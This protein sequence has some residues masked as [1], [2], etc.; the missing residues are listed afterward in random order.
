MR[1]PGRVPDEGAA[2][3]EQVAAT[4]AAAVLVVMVLLAAG[5][6]GLGTE[7]VR[8][9]CQ[10]VTG[11]D[12]GAPQAVPQPQDEEFIPPPCMLAEDGESAGYTVKIAFVEIGEEYGFIRQEFADGTVRLTAVDSATIGLVKSGDTKFIDL[13]KLGDDAE[14]GVSVEVGGGLTFGYGDTWA[15]DSAAQE[16]AMRAQ[17]DDYLIQQQQ[18]RRDSHGGYAL[19][20][21]I[22]NGYV[23]PP[24]D[25]GVSFSKISLDG[26]FSAAFGLQAPTGGTDPAGNDRYIDPNIGVALTLDAGYEVVVEHDREA[27]TQSY[28]YSLSG[29]AAA[30]AN[31]V[32]GSGEISGTT[33]GS[34]QITRNSRG[35]I[36]EISMVSTREGGISGGLEVKNPVSGTKVDGGA[37]GG[38]GSTSATVTTTTLTIDDAADRAIVEGWLTS[39]NE[40]FG[41]PLR[42]TA[43]SLVPDRDVPGD[44]FQNLLY[45]KATVSQVGYDNVADVRNFGL[46]IKA[47]WEFGFAV[48]LSNTSSTARDP[49]YLGAPRNGTRSLLVDTTCQ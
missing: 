5:S 7:F 39:N 34:F 10:V 19:W 46:D 36:V 38:R 45:R 32:V 16:Q 44:P 13:G 20:L 33:T 24:K 22:S 3:L 25:P 27:G 23:D 26:S 4:A 42:L 21:W 2:T 35:E 30:E 8:R 14:G 17:L 6:A 40:Q 48:N 15:F 9:V 41:T 31:M 37:D 49:M 18:L 1:R 43:T 12:C 47:G 28:T 11:G 29:S